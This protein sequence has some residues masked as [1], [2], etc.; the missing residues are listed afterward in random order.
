MQISKKATF[1]WIVPVI[2]ILTGIYFLSLNSDTGK[3]HGT[4]INSKPNEIITDSRTNAH[5]ATMPTHMSIGEI[6]I[7]LNV[8]EGAFDKSTS[9]WT[10]DNTHAFFAKG[11]TTP[12]LYSHN[13]PKLF[14]NLR[15]ANNNSRLVLTYAD[16]S[17]LS[18]KYFA[19]RFIDPNDGSILTESNKDMVILMTCSGLSDEM[20]RVVYFKA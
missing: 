8:A 13:Q 11:T 19:T 10:L 5:L 7:D 12:I 16:G 3:A 15:L 1:A 14:F 18:L 9:T 17:T 20:R 6:G 2:L 4:I